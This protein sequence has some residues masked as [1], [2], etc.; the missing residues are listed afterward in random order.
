[1]SSGSTTFPLDLDMTAPL[2]STMPCVSSRVNGSSCSTSPMSFSTRQK[3][4]E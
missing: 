4:R 3:K 2:R 1:M